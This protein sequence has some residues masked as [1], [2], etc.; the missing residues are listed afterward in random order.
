MQRRFL[1]RMRGGGAGF[2]DAIAQTRMPA[3]TG[4]R[5]Y[6]NA[7]GAR[8]REALEHDHAALAHHLGEARWRALCTDYIAACP[9]RHH[10]LR[11]FGNALPQYLRT[12]PAYADAADLAQLAAFERGLLDSFDAADA[13]PALW[14]DLATLPPAHW[15]TLVPQLHPSVRVLRFDCN[16]VEIWRAAK[17]SHAPPAVATR[18]S[19]WVLWRDAERVGRFRSLAADEA[20]AF[21][22][23]ASGGDLAGLCEVLAASHAAD[24]V[25]GTMLA[26]LQRWCGDGWIRAWESVPCPAQ[27]SA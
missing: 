10:S 20:A 1:E 26:M 2:D 14:S 27:E 4:L 3:G 11:D 23:I 18:A 13:V 6:R 17:R 8:L 7:Y 21:A 16:V 19:A 24:A 25:P 15:P 9:S 22:H 5:I 12:A